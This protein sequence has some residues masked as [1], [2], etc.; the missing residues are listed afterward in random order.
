MIVHMKSGVTADGDRV[1]AVVAKA[2]RYGLV[3]EIHAEPG[4]HFTPVEIYLKDGKTQ[5]SSL[6]EYIFGNMEGVDQV[7]RV[8]P[9]K[10]SAVM[11]GDRERHRIPIG[12]CYIG[13][14][15]PTLLVAGPCMIDRYSRRTLEVLA[16][17]GIKHVRGGFLKPRSRAEACRGFGHQALSDFM[18]V[19][20][21]SGI[22]SVWTEVIE[23][24]DINDVR[25]A[26]DAAKF[27][28]TVVL[29][30]G[31][32]NCGNFRLL[33]E[34]GIQKEFPVML[35]H[36]LH[37]TRV[38]ELFDTAAFVLYGPMKWNDDGSLDKRPSA[39]AGNSKLIFC[40]RGL[41]K[42]DPYD[43]HRFRPNFGWIDE[44]RDRSWAPVC[45][46]PSHMAG[47]WDLVFRDLT[48]GLTHNPDVVL[49]E[50]HIDPCQSLCDQE[51]AIPA[52]RIDEIIDRVDEHNAQH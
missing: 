41:Q 36:G 39:K 42:V 21:Q 8:S 12:N 28:G 13:G 30:V 14:D 24:A 34:L 29:W 16:A 37:M 51:Q 31:A 50:S 23:G 26:R 5:A 2:T 22:E 25:R 40:V 44:L 48:E 35:K 47:R 43:P 46:D 32:R 19:A 6:P 7:V 38:E 33:E 9:A 11:N 52:E 18:L 27:D 1:K 15:E 10:V 49:V 45:L 4:T 20:R 3:P 17:A